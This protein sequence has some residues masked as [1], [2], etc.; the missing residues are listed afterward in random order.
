MLHTLRVALL[1]PHQQ[2]LL[3]QQLEQQQLLERQP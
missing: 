1:F 2:H 3:L